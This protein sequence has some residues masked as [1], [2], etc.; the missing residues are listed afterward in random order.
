MQSPVNVNLLVVQTTDLNRLGAITEQQ[1]FGVGNNFHPQGLFSIEIFGTVGSEYRSRVFGYIDLHTQVIHPTIFK[2]IVEC[3]AFYK[4]II[5]GK[6]TAIWNP[7]TRELEKSNEPEAQT[8]YAFFLSH[9][10][11]IKFE[12]NDSDKRNFYID[13]IEKSIKENTHLARYILVM[14]AGLRDYTVTP[15]GKPEEDEVNTFYRRLLTQSQLVDPSLF[16]KSPSLYDGVVYQLQS[17]LNDL[18]EYIQ[19]LL[20]GKNKLILGKWLSRKIF[21]STRNVLTASVDNTIEMDDPNRLRSNDA[22][23]GLYQFLRASCPKSL[24]AIKTTYVDKIFSENNNFCYLTNAK[25]LKKEEVLSSHVQKDYDRWM[26]MQGLE[27]IIAGFGNLD[28][29]HMS[30]TLNAGKHFMGLLYN[31]GKYVKFLQDISELPEHLNKSNVSPITMAEF[32][33]LSVYQLSGTLPAFVTRYPIN[34]YGGI[35]P[36]MMQ[37]RTTTLVHKLTL[38]NDQWRESENILTAFPVRG[39][40]FFN[41]MSVHQSHMG[42]LG[43]DFDGDTVS[44]VGVQSDEAIEEVKRVLNSKTYYLN[45][46]NKVIFSNSSDIIDATLAFMTRD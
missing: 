13:L 2:A 37:L 3:K 29:R 1:I 14:P 11:Q 15:D 36:C 32:L 27:S 7:K 12:K 45:N 18:F 4:Q 39:E 5:Q 43:A 40:P 22:A 26:T 30:L 41:G 8:G 19:S 25:T 46:E 6:L 44:L 23:V 31:D 20:D 35:Y 10:S 33:Y 17:T 38:L 9:L 21:N 34:G 16:V 42:L 24:F 28:I